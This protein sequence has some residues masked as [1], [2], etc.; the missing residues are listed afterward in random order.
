LPVLGPPGTQSMCDHLE[1]AFAFDRKV[2]GRDGRYSAAGVT[3]AV[4]DVDPGVVWEAGGVK[5]TAFEVDHGDGIAPAYGYRVDYGAYSA[6]FSGDMR[7]DERIVEH[8]KGVDVLVMEVVSAELEMRKAAVKDE[9]TIAKI[10]AHHIG[11]EQAGS[12]FARIRPR[13]AVYTHVVPSPAVAEDLIPPTRRT[14]GGPLA[15][16]YDL[17]QITIGDAV[18][19]H[20]RRALPD[21]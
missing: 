15:V 14:Y 7:Y 5:V 12:L 11:E 1:E 2:R 9:A 8:A 6:A 13:L 17:M 10:I 20:P 3:I 21:S 19:V 4:T 18:E 16:G